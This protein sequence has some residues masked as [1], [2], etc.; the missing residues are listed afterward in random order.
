MSLIEE[1]VL[2]AEYLRGL[3][4]DP[5]KALRRLYLDSNRGDLAVKRRHPEISFFS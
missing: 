4:G 3:C 5:A 1:K 2:L